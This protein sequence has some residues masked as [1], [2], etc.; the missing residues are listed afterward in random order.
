MTP[1]RLAEL[2]KLAV[3]LDQAH[4]GEGFLE[5]RLA[6]YRELYDAAANPL[7]VSMVEK[8]RSD[9]GR[10]WLRRRVAHGHEPQHAMLLRY[11]RSRDAEGAVNWLTNHLT[12]VANELAA[13]VVNK[14][15]D[16]A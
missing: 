5:A 2:E 15:E 3:T 13:L 16:G 6:F 9:V 4:Q 8:L 10:Y 7:I 12:E 14:E 11:V 1:E